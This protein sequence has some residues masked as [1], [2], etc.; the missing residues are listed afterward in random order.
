M[1]ETWVQSLRGGEPLEEEMAT[2][3][4]I[5]ARKIQWT[6]EAGRLQSVG[7]PR[8]GHDLVTN[9]GS[10]GA[11]SGFNQPVS[12]ATKRLR[13]CKTLIPKGGGGPRR[14]QVQVLCTPSPPPP[15]MCCPQPVKAL[16]VE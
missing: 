8:D 2:H 10:H 16:S 13:L 6:E 1:K 14:P 15:T 3:S 4:R 12:L 9:I 7:S 11:E 5:L